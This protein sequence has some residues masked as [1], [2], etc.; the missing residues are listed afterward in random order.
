MELWNRDDDFRKDYIRNNTRSTLWRLGT[1]DG[2]SLGPDEEPPVVPDFAVNSRATKQNS[3]PLTKIPEQEKQEVPEKV[4][5]LDDKSGAKVVEREN[6]IVKTTKKPAKPAMSSGTSPVTNSEK[7][8]RKEK[9][10][11]EEEEPI[12]S[13]EEEELARKAEELRKVEEAAQLKQ[14]RNL[15]EKAKAKEAMERKKR[16][17][18]KAQARAAI[19][20]QKEAEQKE[21]VNF[22]TSVLH[23]C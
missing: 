6:Q 4:E 14:Q 3:V 12:R 23:L 22:A 10:K 1:F 2:R 7:D 13:K 19:R 18:E 17:T 21:K 9:E 11:E 8:E 20:A 15:E 5:K 16:I